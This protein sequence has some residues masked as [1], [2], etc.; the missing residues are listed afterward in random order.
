MA[1][2]ATIGAPMAPQIPS[3]RSVVQIGT[4]SGAYTRSVMAG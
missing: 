3:K 4:A 2:N 1:Q